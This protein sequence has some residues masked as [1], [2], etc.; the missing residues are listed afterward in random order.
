MKETELLADF[1]R[2]IF[3]DLLGYTG[4]ASFTYSIA[5]ADGG[6]SSA[7][8]TLTV[9]VPVGGIVSPFSGGLTKDGDGNLVLGAALNSYT[10]A[11]SLNLGGVQIGAALHMQLI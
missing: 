10:G 1:I 11:T 9:N 3:S 2:D 4:P 6:T 7:N 8:V 5:D